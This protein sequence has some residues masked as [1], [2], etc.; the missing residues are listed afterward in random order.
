MNKK[1]FAGLFIISLIVLAGGCGGSNG[2]LPGKTSLNS[3]LSGAWSSSTNGTAAITSMNNESDDLET[4][5]EAFGEIPDELLAEY[6]EAKKNAAVESADVPVT[7]AV[8]FFDDGSLDGSSGT[9]KLTAIVI[10]S[11]D[12]L[13]LPLFYHDVAI[14]TQSSNA[15]EWTASTPDGGTLTINMAS[16]ETIN[17]SGKVNYLDYVCEFSTVI[18]KNAANS[19]NP[20]EILD[21]TW[22]LDDKQ[23]GGYVAVNSNI[24][25]SIIPEAVSMHFKDTQ[26][27]ASSVTS[28]VASFYSVYMKT[29][30]TESNE[31]AS[32]WQTIYPAGSETLTQITDNVY[33]FTEDNSEGILFV[34]NTDEIFVFMTE[35][36]NSAWQTCMFIPLKKVAFDLESAMNKTW[37]VSDGGGYSGTDSFTLQAATLNFSDIT[38][39][40]DDTVTATVNINASFSET[41]NNASST[42]YAYTSQSTLKRFGNFLSV[43]DESDNTVYNLSFIS[44]TEAFLAISGQ[45]TGDYF[46]LRFKAD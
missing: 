30:N 19:I 15:N 31:D 33:K 27:T 8:A 29:A 37:T 46:V 2:P 16:E 42:P 5:I 18:E 14:S 17:L 10:L 43:E 3:A 4:L 26:Q 40:D 39:N 22:K 34:E 38:A 41:N 23:G 1:F 7:S 24:T 9:P 28:S 25:A 11:G 21:G 13:C 12:D 36:G 32:V 44:D 20:Q 45:N 35:N 6:E